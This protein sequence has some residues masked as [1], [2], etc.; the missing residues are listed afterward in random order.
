MI[1]RV[2]SFG[3]DANEFA[4]I[5]NDQGSNVLTGHQFERFIHGRRR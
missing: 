3:H 2:Y 5:E 1:S 4:I